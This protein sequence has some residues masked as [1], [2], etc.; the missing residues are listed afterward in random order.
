MGFP[1]G[2]MKKIFSALAF[3]TFLLAP[4]ASRLTPSA[5]AAIGDTA[6]L[7]QSIANNA[8]LDIQPGSG[9]EWIIHNLWFEDNVE[10]QR[11]DGTN[12]VAVAQFTQGKLELTTH[13]TNSNRIR[14]KNIQGAS[15]KLIC[16]DG[17]QS[18]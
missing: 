13:V 16:Y 10:L 2:T 15:A 9:V 17:I 8:F 5:E 3:L 14:V 1:E 4:H 6:A 11:Y 18:K 7:C 12:A